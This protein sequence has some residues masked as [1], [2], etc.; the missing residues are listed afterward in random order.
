MHCKKYSKVFPCKEDIPSF[1]VLYA[2]VTVA[3][4]INIIQYK[5]THKRRGVPIVK[6][7]S[8]DSLWNLRRIFYIVLKNTMSFE[9]HFLNPRM[10]FSWWSH[11][12]ILNICQFWCFCYT[13][14]YNFCAQEAF[15]YIRQLHVRLVNWFW[16]NLWQ[17]QN[18]STG[19]SKKPISCNG[20]S[21]LL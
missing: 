11:L 7:V 10:D 19:Q 6:N 18:H 21:T 17:R 14:D 4:G 12:I 16:T 9:I 2:Y 20:P 5:I 8:Q 15:Y 3:Q 13:S 1:D